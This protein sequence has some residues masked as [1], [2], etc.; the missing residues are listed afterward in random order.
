MDRRSVY[1]VVNEGVSERVYLQ[2]LRS[3]L[4]KR[5]PLRDDFYVRL[6]LVPR[7]ARGG[8]QGGGAF[9]LIRRKYLACRKTDRRTPIVIWVDADIYV[10]GANLLE[11]RNA[12][13]YANR[14]AL[15]AFY[16]SVMNFEDFLALHFDD[17]VF[18]RWYAVMK[19]AGHFEAPL[20]AKTY[21]PLFAP[22]WAD[23]VNRMGVRRGTY[24]KGT[25]PVDFISHVTLGNMIR[26]TADPRIQ[27]LFRATTKTPTFAEYLSVR[28]REQ[29]PEVFG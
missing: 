24:A 1:I 19:E 3:F 8:G 23:Q 27:S 7:M 16:F 22:L 2:L 26:H 15:P 5:M 9:S 11:E 18:E 25:L 29:Y 14:G 28:L 4:T 12:R 13:S 6:D 21:K 17:D 10:R 20:V